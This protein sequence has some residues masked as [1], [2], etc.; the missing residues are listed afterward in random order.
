VNEIVGLNSL[1]LSKPISAGTLG[2]SKT[3]VPSFRYAIAGG[4]ISVVS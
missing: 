1:Y 4:F 3:T 2:F